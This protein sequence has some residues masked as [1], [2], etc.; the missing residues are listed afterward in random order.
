MKKIELKGLCDEVEI[1]LNNLRDCEIKE[2][3][4]SVQVVFG[5]EGLTVKEE[6][7]PGRRGNKDES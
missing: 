3:D 6:S 2:S 4:G 5:K 1:T 7:D